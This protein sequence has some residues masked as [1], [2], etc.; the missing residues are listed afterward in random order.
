MYIAVSITG[1]TLD[2]ALKDIE[3][4][5][6]KQPDILEL[7]IDFMQD[8]SESALDKLIAACSL[9]VI[10]TNRHKSEAG[11]DPRAGFD[12]PE[13]QRI[14][15]LQQ[16]IALG[17]EHIDIEA[18]HYHASHYSP[19][20]KRK[21]NLI[22]SYHDFIQT[23]ERLID[24]YKAIQRRVKKTAII[25]FATQANTPEDVRRMMELIEYAN[26]QHTPIIGICMGELGRETRLHRG[27]YLTFACLS[28]EQASAGG[29][30]TVEQIREKLAKR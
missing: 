10:V 9:P 24:M 30:Y 12:G 2:Q 25:K 1:Q 19:S 15:Y 29:Q 8:L 20:D 13:E 3:V 4:A 23:P 6:K 27:N 17:A 22:V 11:P 14:A 7:R 28:E 18:C 26:A 16:A 21:T 5:E